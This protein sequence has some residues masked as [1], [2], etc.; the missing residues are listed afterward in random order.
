MR[1][2]TVTQRNPLR[3]PTISP[4]NAVVRKSRSYRKEKKDFTLF[5][6]CSSQFAFWT[7]TF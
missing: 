7:S 3:N 2:A 5:T 6:V 4:I 1:M